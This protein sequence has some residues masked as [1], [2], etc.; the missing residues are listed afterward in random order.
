MV[1]VFEV[2]SWCD[3]CVVNLLYSNSVHLTSSLL[4]YTD[5]MLEAHYFEVLNTHAQLS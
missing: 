2:G 1:F 3:L 4:C 5:L